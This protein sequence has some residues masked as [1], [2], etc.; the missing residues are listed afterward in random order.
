VNIKERFTTRE[1][2]DALGHF[3]TGVTVVTTQGSQHPYGMTANAF[4]SVSLEPPL[5]LVCV[6]SGTEGENSIRD[7]GVFAVNVL[8]SHQEAISRYFSDS[9]RP[10][11]WATFERIAHTRVSTGSPVLDGVAAYFDCRLVATHDAG[12]HVIFIGEV[13]GLGLDS[14]VK[15]LLYH[16]GRYRQ[17]SEQS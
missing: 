13:E 2:R 10:R 15:P 7:N 4:A 12:D 16:L 17:V 8:G 14:E 5:V 9:G 6:V 1:F 11:G 3:A